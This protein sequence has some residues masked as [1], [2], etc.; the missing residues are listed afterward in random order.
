MR[1][2]GQDARRPARSASERPVVLI[3]L[4]GAA[5]FLVTGAWAFLAPGSF[6]DVVAPWPPYNRHF[7]H[8]VGAF[9]IGLGASLLLALAARDALLVAL[10]GV[11]LASALHALS[12]LVDRDLGGRSSDPV[13]LAV[14]AAVIILGAVLRARSRPRD[15]VRS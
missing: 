2:E 8:D 12:H 1:S 3:A 7:L 13:N 15:R 11:G 9:S 4:L 14:L 5:F 6:Y 10:A